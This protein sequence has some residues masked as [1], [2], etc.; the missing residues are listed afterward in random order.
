MSNEVTVVLQDRKT[1]QRRN[2]TINVNNNENI[3]ELTKSVEKITKIPS[4]ELEVVFC[5]KKLS[6]STIMKDLSL[7]PATQIMLL[8]PNSVVKTATSSSKFQTTDSSILG[9][10]YVWC[11]S[12]DDVRRGKLRVYCQNCE[13]TSVLVKAEPQ[14]WMD[15]LKSKRIPVTS[16]ALTHVRG[17]W[18]MAECCICDG[19]EKIIFDLG[20]NHISCQS[21]FKDYLL[22]TLQVFHFKNRPPYG[23][24]V[25][26]VY[27]ECNR[28]VQDVHHFHVMG[29]S[30]YSEYQRKATERLIAIDDEGVTCPNPS[31]GQSFFWEPYDDDGRSQCPDCF[32]TFC[33]KCTERDCVCQS[34][35]DLTRTTIEATTRRCP[36]CNVATE[37]NGGCAHIHCTSCGMDWCFKCVTEWK[38]ECQWDHCSTTRTAEMSG[39]GPPSNLTPQQQHFVDDYA[40]AA[41]TTNDA[42]TTDSTTAIAPKTVATTASATAADFQSYQRSRTP[43]MQQH[44]GGGSPGSHL[45]MHP[46][47]QS[48][49]HMQPRSPLV[50]QHHPAPGSIPPGNPATP[51]MM[52]QQMGMNQPMSLPA[53]HVSRPGSVAPPASV[54]P[55]MHTGPSSNQMDQMGG[56]SQYSHH[57]QPQQPL[58]RPG[59]QQ[60]HI[61]GGHGGPHSV[62]Q[63]GSIQRPGSVLAPGSIQQPGSL[64]APGSMHQPG[65]VQQPG[66]L[67]APLSHT[68][69]GGPQSVQGYGPG[70]V[71]PPGSAQA[72][73]S[74]QPGSTFAPGSLQ[75][76]ASQQPPAS[77]QPPPSAASGS[78]AGPASAA[79][80]KVEPLKPNEEQIR[81][82]QD[83]VDLVRNLVQKDLRMSVVEMNKRG[84]EL[85]HQKEEGA[86]KEEDRQQYKRATNDF[87][88]VCDEIDRTLTTIMETA[89]QITKLDK[90]FQD[91][92]SKEIDGEAMV[93]SVQKFV[94][95]TGIVQKMFD[96]TVNSVTSTMEKMRRR[97]KKWKDQQQQQENAEDA[98][99]AE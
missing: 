30:S 44:P 36:K 16:A 58:S 37:R 64:L 84:A 12:C 32:Y 15:V 46:H 90:V 42:T 78:V 95:E 77:I 81:M 50:G 2:Y 55:N 74:V 7:T 48:Q 56:Q 72:P 28:V 93:N 51:Q 40:A 39:Q 29:Q 47:L 27:P 26:C 68:G 9:S 88:A 11:K 34:E 14:N 49:G 45:Q 79:P 3:L 73:S 75:A 18:Q 53:P 92:T 71:Q 59:S 20:C 97:Q 8:R 5:G 35:D 19:K 80:A 99:M 67:G 13:S 91:R 83:P 31:C 63:P 60:S 10:F 87:H 23:F 33:R 25:S 70:S 61:A 4:E 41:T 86:I 62:Q 65:S 69:A 94:D 43:Q 38:E 57:L 1:G 82:V 76:P 24:T 54:P 89:K 6:K 85:L 98:E 96:D 21:C 66:S 22:S 52:Q 17:N